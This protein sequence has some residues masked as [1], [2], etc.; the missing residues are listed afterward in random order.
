MGTVS[1]ESSYFVANTAL[2]ASVLLV[3]SSKALLSAP[4]VSI[5]GSTLRDNIA[6]QARG[7]VIVAEGGKLT[8]RDSIVAHSSCLSCLG[9][10]AQSSSTAFELWRGANATFSGVI[11]VSNSQGVGFVNCSDG[12]RRLFS[13]VPASGTLSF[14]CP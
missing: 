8:L 3:H 4:V 13:D 11:I 9:K 2:Q 6:V 14:E 5:T 7:Y 1:V 10:A 12:T